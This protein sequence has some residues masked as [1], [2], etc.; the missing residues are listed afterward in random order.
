MAVFAFQSKGINDV[1]TIRAGS[2]DHRT[3]QVLDPGDRVKFMQGAHSTN[4]AARALQIMNLDAFGV[5][6]IV[7]VSIDGEMP[8]KKKIVEVFK[9][10]KELA[11]KVAERAL[12]QPQ[13]R[14]K[15]L[16][17]KTTKVKFHADD[18][19]LREG[20]EPAPD[21]EPTPAKGGGISLGDLAA[22]A[23]ADMD[24]VAADAGVE[25]E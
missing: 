16:D 12:K 2:I 6:R 23:K 13:A 10:H 9:E 18:E 21:P 4:D 5:G 11:A 20:P 8:T 3:G 14:P 22:G 19:T 24:A 17:P 1:Y 15:A 25:R 7:L